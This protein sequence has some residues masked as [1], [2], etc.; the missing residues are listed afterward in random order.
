MG[1][2]K[3]GF[4]GLKGRIWWPVLFVFLL[5]GCG[6]G[7]GG[8]TSTDTTTGTTQ[9]VAITAS[10]DAILAG[11][12]DSS[13]L[14]ITVSPAADGTVVDLQASGGT[15]NHSSVTTVNGLASATVTASS[16]GSIV[17]TA[18][19]A[20]TS[21]TTAAPTTIKAVSNFSDLFTKTPTGTATLVNS[22]TVQSGSTFG[23]TIVNTAHRTFNLQKAQ[24][25]DGATVVYSTT[26]SLVL[27]GGLISYNVSNPFNDTYQTNVDLPITGSFVWT[28]T[29]LDTP[30]NEQ[31]TISYTYPIN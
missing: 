9:T 25:V 4:G 2:H 5:S 21:V 11:G 30:T 24:L 12:T 31:F 19:I 29:L 10:T 20:G 28:Y 15:L 8:S 13:T 22:T 6:G 23:L 16:A 3:G 18:T 27:N 26:D 1:T 14:A 17:I 7:G